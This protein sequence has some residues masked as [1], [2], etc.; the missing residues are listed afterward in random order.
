MGFELVYCYQ[1]KRRLSEEEFQQGKAFR[2]GIHTT[3]MKCADS[4]LLELTPEQRDAVLNPRTEPPPGP[5]QTDRFAKPATPRAQPAAHA[6]PPASRGLNPA[7]LIGAGVVIGIIV[8]VLAFSGSRNRPQDVPAPAPKPH[9]PDKP[10]PAPVPPA[11]TP[12]GPAPV[13]YD[14]RREGPGKLALEKARDLRKSKPD[15]LAGI[16]QLFEQAVMECEKTPFADEA[17]R[18]LE[19]AVAR[20]QGSFAPALGALE[21]EIR[22]LS[23]RTEYQKALDRIEAVRKK[24]DSPEWSRAVDAKTKEILDA[25]EGNFIRMKPK[26]KEARGRPD[27]IKRLR[28]QVDLWGIPRY[29]DDFEK[30]LSGTLE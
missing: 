20:L 19:Q 6:K 10:A 13:T 15:D 12:P 22:P 29:R 11:P 21:T 4:L 9:A 7:I 17:M 18:E 25:A 28:D 1:C 5:K 14:A 27:D 8:L 16:V 3:C 24:F 30:V 26:I 2:I 23:E